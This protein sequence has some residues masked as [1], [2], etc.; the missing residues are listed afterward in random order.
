M[1]KRLFALL[2]ALGMLTTMLSGFCTQLRKSRPRIG[3]GSRS[4]VRSTCIRQG[5]PQHRRGERFGGHPRICRGRRGIPHS[6]RR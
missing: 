1:K 5:S 6:K 4:P 3:F 2:L